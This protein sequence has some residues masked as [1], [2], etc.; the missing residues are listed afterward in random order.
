MII[1]KLKDIAIQ[2][3]ENWASAEYAHAKSLG[4]GGLGCAHRVDKA[5]S[6]TRSAIEALASF[7]SKVK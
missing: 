7:V 2:A 3:A 5:E 1:D 4:A 6:D